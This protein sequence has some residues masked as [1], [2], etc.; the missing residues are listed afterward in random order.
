MKIVLKLNV[1]V[2]LLFIKKHHTEVRKADMTQ[3]CI[4]QQRILAVN[5]HVVS[6]TIAFKHTS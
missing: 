1:G 6:V 3:K 2:F 4:Q 5:R